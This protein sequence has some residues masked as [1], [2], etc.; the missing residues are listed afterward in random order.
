MKK[1]I[2]I[3][4][5]FISFV[6]IGQNTKF[7]IPS[8]LYAKDTISRL[9]TRPWVLQQFVNFRDTLSGVG[10]GT[11][12]VTNVA[13]VGGTGIS[14]TGSPITT[15]GTFT[16]TNSL[17]MVYPGAGIAKSTGSA[18]TT[19][20][21]DSSA[22]WSEAYS[23][24]DHS[25]MGYI[26][27]STLNELDPVFAGDSA[28]LL[29]KTDTV[30]VS[31]PRKKVATLYDLD[32]LSFSSTESDPIYASSAAASVTTTTI[33][34]WNT[35]YGW[36]NHSG[37]YFAKAD[38]NSNGNAATKKYVDGLIATKK[39]T[40]E[41]IPLFAIGV[42]ST[43]INTT[44]KFPFGYSHGIVLDTVAI[45]ATTTASGGSVN[46]TV[47]IHYGTDISASGTA[48]VTDGTAMTSRTTATKV[49][50]FDNATIAKPNMIW[51]T[52]SS[53][54]TR[55]RNIYIQLMGHKQ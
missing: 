20:L 53:I 49:S 26:T 29:Y 23:W 8:Y 55:P 10:G 9:A 52:F 21:V 22:Y 34:N 45:L 30:Y 47:K 2:T 12:T 28:D 32:T 17:P 11:G 18:W 14:I 37:V 6:T 46:V 1:L 5:L 41:I 54:T 27:T 3:L 35:A 40:S 50:S 7:N 39:S 43:M 4:L 51:L 42:D 33:S 36:G 24:G 16:I 48:I 38:S 31:G 15:S 25:T 19:S 44:H 13:A